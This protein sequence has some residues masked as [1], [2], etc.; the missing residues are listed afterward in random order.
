MSQRKKGYSSMN[1][2]VMP[3]RAVLISA[4]KRASSGLEDQILA[5]FTSS[6]M[7]S[8]RSSKNMSSL[9]EV[10][11]EQPLYRKSSYNNLS[12]HQKVVVQMSE[13]DRAMLYAEP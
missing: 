8:S 10:T 11:K 13:R 5:G 3:K 7:N 6:R 1:Q 12:N 4:K 2:G 9:D